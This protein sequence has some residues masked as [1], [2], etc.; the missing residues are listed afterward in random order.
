MS[1]T[2]EYLDKI[3]DS[4]ESRG[5]VKEALEIDRVADTVDRYYRLVIG[6][7]RMP[8]GEYI[9]WDRETEYP[10]SVDKVRVLGVGKDSMVKKDNGKYYEGYKRLN[11]LTEPSMKS[12]KEIT[13]EEYEKSKK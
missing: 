1:I 9:W 13:K 8:S 5:L 3:A 4:L 12:I 10:I 7:T 6:Y 2:S 11:D